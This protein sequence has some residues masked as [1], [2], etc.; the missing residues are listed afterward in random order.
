[1][2]LVNREMLKAKIRDNGFSYDSLAEEIY[3][4]PETIDNIVNGRTKPSYISMNLIMHA[5]HLTSEEAI[6]IFFAQNLF[7]KRRNKHLSLM[8]S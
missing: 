3:V 8:N 1:M 4:N 5:L 2:N 6:A 7:I